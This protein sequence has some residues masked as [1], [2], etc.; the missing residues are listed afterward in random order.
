[1]VLEKEHIDNAPSSEPGL[2]K[3]TFLQTKA[4]LSFRGVCDEESP[5]RLALAE[6]DSSCLS[7]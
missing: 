7:G 5:L 3:I 1:M 2:I 6:G 4:A